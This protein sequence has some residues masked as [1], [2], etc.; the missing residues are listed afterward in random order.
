MDYGICIDKTRGTWVGAL[1]RMEVLKSEQGR[2]LASLSPMRSTI[3][4]MNVVKPCVAVNRGVDN[5]TAEQLDA[6]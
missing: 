4:A 6:C 2:K 1:I 5:P 3:L